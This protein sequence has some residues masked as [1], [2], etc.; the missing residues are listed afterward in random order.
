M[1][2]ILDEVITGFRVRPGGFQG[3]CDI[4]PDLTTLA[5][6]LAGGFPGGCVGGRADLMQVLAFDNPLGKKMKHPGTYNGN[7]LSAAAGVACL[8]IVATGEPATSANAWPRSFARTQQAVRAKGCRTG[9]RTATFSAIKIHPDYDG[10]RP[11]DDSFIPFDNDYRKLDRIV[12][13]TASRT[14]FA[15]HLLLGG[16]DWMGWGGSTMASHTQA[17]VDRTVEAFDAA[18]DLLHSRRAGELVST[19]TGRD[20]RPAAVSRMPDFLREGRPRRRSFSR[21]PFLRRHVSAAA[22]AAQTRTFELIE[23][24]D[25]RL[26]VAIPSGGTSPA[27]WGSLRSFGMDFWRS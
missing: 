20:G 24:S 22:R 26:V 25:E 16:V 15:A 3:F 10:P 27:F 8:E 9:W 23:R 1:I 19:T 2:F 4:T 18:I 21:V 17:D 5:K 11:V 7:P 6:V 14:P 12:R 13:R